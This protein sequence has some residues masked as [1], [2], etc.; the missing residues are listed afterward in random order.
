MAR[1]GVTSS[2]ERKRIRT[3]GTLE[4]M[5]DEQSNSC[6]ICAKSFDEVGPPHVD[7]CYVCG[8]I[9]HLLCARCNAGLGY[10]DD[11]PRVLI[12]AAMYVEQHIERA[13]HD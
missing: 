11:D 1:T 6:W 7:H 9:R 5:L 4:R 13:P 2:K 12:Q 10:F 3:D 8:E